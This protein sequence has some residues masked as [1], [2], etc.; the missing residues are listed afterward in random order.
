MPAK[1]QTETASEVSWA[2]Q[3][4][5]PR[6]EKLPLG[7]YYCI[8]RDSTW[9]LCLR[10]AVYLCKRTMQNKQRLELADYEAENLARLQKTFARKWEFVFM[11]AEAQAKWVSSRCLVHS[12]P[13]LLETRCSR[14][15]Q[16]SPLVPSLSELDETWVLSFILAYSLHYMKTWRNP[17]NRKY[18]CTCRI[19]LPP[20]TDPLT[21][22]GNI[23][24]NFD[25][26]IL[27]YAS[28]HTD[29]Q[30]DIKRHVLI[31]VLR[32]PTGAK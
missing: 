10:A 15:L 31:T 13:F 27:R 7:K 17:Q 23:Y 4:V 1:T 8:S 21:A 3:Q 24:R 22:A 30:T 16:T 11:Q 6:T 26:W 20:E 25:V 29:K 28:G 14:R 2:P 9:D 12:V 19:A 32:T 18:A 5:S